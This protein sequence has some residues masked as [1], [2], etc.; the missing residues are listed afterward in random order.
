MT[1]VNLITL[2]MTV[3]VLFIF[4]VLLSLF[5]R[6][7]ELQ[8]IRKKLLVGIKTFDKQ[9][10]EKILSEFKFA[11]ASLAKTS[12]RN[13]ILIVI[14]LA[15]TASLLLSVQ[16]QLNLVFTLL[17][18]FVTLLFG[19]LLYRV[20]KKRMARKIV[21]QL[22]NA[23]DLV[24]HF[25]SLNLPLSDIIHRLAQNTSFPIARFFRRCNLKIKA[26]ASAATAIGDSAR[27]LRI[28]EV[29]YFAKILELQQSVGTDTIKILYR[30]SDLLRRQRVLRKKI[31]SITL[32]NR[33][34]MVFFIVL[35]FIFI[36][37]LY[38][39]FPQYQSPLFTT[40]AGH[41]LLWIIAI[42]YI[43]GYWFLYNIL[44]VD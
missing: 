1:L 11:A 3:V 10:H 26:G 5:F 20:I 36:A 14:I 35:P 12:Q 8:Q 44:R 4:F 30:F 21:D 13:L 17:I 39:L 33:F 2:L 38:L 31:D 37:L 16:I 27:K 42:L 24:I 6:F 25:S 23:I 40:P 19:L 32:E 34:A 28:F 7:V 9:E 22:P 18:F 15:I 41:R 43:L 29:D